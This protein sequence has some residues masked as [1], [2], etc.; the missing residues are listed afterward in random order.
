[1]LLSL[2]MICCYLAFGI[3]TP[4]PPRVLPRSWQ[5]VWGIRS[6]ALP[7]PVAGYSLSLCRY[8]RDPPRSSQGASLGFYWKSFLLISLCFF[9]VIS[10][11]FRSCLIP[12]WSGLYRHPSSSVS[13]HVRLKRWE[14][15]SVCSS[16]ASAG[17]QTMSSCV[18]SSRRVTLAL[19]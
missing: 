1:M 19:A 9:A 2:P 5:F 4:L 3:L 13:C 12:G 17:G 11:W 14:D 16:S 10:L 6:G 15:S 18:H 8:R 7:A